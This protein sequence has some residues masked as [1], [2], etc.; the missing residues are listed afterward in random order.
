MALAA[1]PWLALALMALPLAPAWRDAERRGWALLA[2]AALALF[3]L[4]RELPALLADGLPA[5]ARRLIS[6]WGGALCGLAAVLL[7]ARPLLLRGLLAPRD[8]G[9]TLRQ[10]PGSLPPTLAASAALLA[11]HFLATRALPGEPPA[12][13]VQTWL[14]QATLPGL[15]EEAAFRGLLLACAVRALPR[16]GSAGARLGAGG[17]LVTAAFVVL[18]GISAASAAGLLSGVLPAALLFLWLRARTGSL[19]LPVVV[20]NLWNVA[21]YA[22]RL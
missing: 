6:D 16:R 4:A 13:A 19:L 18:H 15:A 5:G 3:L 7:V 17:L 20:H 22:A 14:Y 1:S 10:A 2:L 8:L 11:L 21:A 12:V 9:F